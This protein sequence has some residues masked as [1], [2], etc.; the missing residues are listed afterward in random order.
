MKAVLTKVAL[1]EADAGIVYVT[2]VKAAGDT[3]GRRQ[4]PG[5]PERDHDVPDRDR[6]GQQEL[7]DRCR[8]RRVRPLARGPEGARRRRVLAHR[9]ATARTVGHSSPLAGGRRPPRSPCSSSPCRCWALF[10]RAPWGRLWEILTS[11]T[12]LDALRLSLVTAD[13]RD[14]AR[15]PRRGAAR[16][17]AGARRVPRTPAR[18]LAGHGAARA[19][20]GGRRHR[21]AAGFRPSRVRRPVPRLLL[22]HHAAVHHGG[23][24]GRRGVRRDA[25]PRHHRRGCAA[26]DRTRGLRGRRCHARRRP[27]RRLPPRHPPAGAA[28][29][30]SPA[31]VLTFARALG[32]FGATITFAGNLPGVT[33]T[34]P[35]AVYVGLEGDPAEAGDARVSCSSPSPS[36]CSWPCATAGC[37][38]GPRHDARPARARRRWRAAA[39]GSTPRSPWRQGRSW[40]SSARTAPARSTLLRC[41]RGLVRLDSGRIELAGAV[42]DD[43]AADVS[44]DPASDGSASCSRTTCSSRTCPSPTTSPS[45]PARRTVACAGPRADA[46]D[47]ARPARPAPRSP[48]AGPPSSPADRPSASRSPARSRR[49]PPCSC[50]TSR[51]RR[52]TRRRGSTCA[53]EL[54]SHLRDARRP[55]AARDARPARRA[56]PRRPHRRARGGQHHPAGAA[57]WRSRGDRPPTTSR[58]CSGSTCCAGAPRAATSRSTAA[59][60]CTCPT[61]VPT[62]TCS[63][64]V[65]PERRRP[66]RRAA[67]GER[68]QRLAG[69]GRRRRAD[70]RPRPR[71]SDGA[72]RRSWST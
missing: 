21:A 42:V 5:R 40:P 34:L 10:L 7:R 71:H 32:E 13:E 29:R 24:G 17:A 54:R 60:C 23:R 57:L 33:Q 52:S 69:G 14:G 36:S 67:R 2:D 59:A 44:V 8:V 39:S 30:S 28:R 65:R 4:H 1:G 55:H 48:T 47:V 25:V 12:S 22:R 58:G 56:R 35:L 37:A 6:H 11:P 68:A 3:V 43:P 51:W 46:A 64:R 19:P 50:S 18:P 53:A 27:P 41:G 66:A 15:L 70:R 62:A 45:V 63:W 38:R 31:A 26:H 20:A 49:T 16:V 9:D 61:A 72:A